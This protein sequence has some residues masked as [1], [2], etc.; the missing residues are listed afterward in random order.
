ME[1]WRTCLQD[2]FDLESLA[3]V[4]AELENGEITWS[5]TATTAPS[6]FASD[7]VWKQTNRLMYEDDQPE[8][9]GQ[10]PLRGDLL[11]E[12]VFGSQLRPRLPVGLIDV[13]ERKLQRLYPGYAP[14][15]VEDLVEWVRERVVLPIGEWRELLAAIQRD[16]DLGSEEI[17][18]WLEQASPRL[19]SGTVAAGEEPTVVVHWEQVPRL[20]RLVGFTTGDPLPEAAEPVTVEA[21]EIDPLVELVAEWI[22]FYGPF[23]R[24]LLAGHLGLGDSQVEEVLETL[25][26]EERVVIDQFRQGLEEDDGLEICDTENLER[27]LRLLRTESRPSFTA[28]PLTELP[29]FLATRQGLAIGAADSDGLMGAL[30]RLFGYPAAVRLWESELLPARLEPY[31]TRWL[32]GLFHDT[33]LVWLGTGREQIT[34]ALRHDL[35]LLVDPQSTDEEPIDDLER[36]FPPQPGRYSLDE[37][38]TR[39][40]GGSL[41]LLGRGNLRGFDPGGFDHAFLRGRAHL[42]QYAVDCLIVDRLHHPGCPRVLTASPKQQKACPILI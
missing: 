1:T 15:G 11:R 13:F 30:E 33:D 26:A 32:D 35:D 21:G 36:I 7:I 38:A 19:V 27:L 41:R 40:G 22:R 5:E 23:D 9:S 20:S 2:E 31:Y 39:V 37:L 25:V 42:R 4:L 17:E 6:P 28:R 16:Q 10:S 3:R 34:L 29:L 12:L 14:Q 24:S 18:D 8:D